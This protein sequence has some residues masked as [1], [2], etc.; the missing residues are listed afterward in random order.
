M[1]LRIHY[2]SKSGDMK[3]QDAEFEKPDDG[4]HAE[5]SDEDYEDS[6]ARSFGQAGFKA[7]SEDAG[8][9]FWIS[10]QWVIE[11][12]KLSDTGLEVE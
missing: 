5:M 7:K 12:E 9:T 8:R 2:L 10:P 11:V 1:K 6:I 4:P 3:W